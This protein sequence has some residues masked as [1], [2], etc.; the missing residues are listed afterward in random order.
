[1]IKVIRT[2]IMVIIPIVISIVVKLIKMTTNKIWKNYNLI[3][4]LYLLK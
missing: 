4:K 3:V 2:Y 1:M